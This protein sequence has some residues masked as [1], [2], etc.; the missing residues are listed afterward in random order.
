MLRG[1]IFGSAGALLFT[2]IEIIVA[3]V[4]YRRYKKKSESI[5]KGILLP[6]VILLCIAIVIFTWK[7]L[8]G[9]NS[10]TT[11]SKVDL[12]LVSGLTEAVLAS[13]IHLLAELDGMSNYMEYNENNNFLK[14]YCALYHRIGL[15]GERMLG[16][17]TIDIYLQKDAETAKSRLMLNYSRFDHYDYG[18]N[19]AYLG[20]AEIVRGVDTFMLGGTGRY[21]RTEIR[22]GRYVISISERT[23]SY[24]LSDLRT[25]DVLKILN[26]I[27]LE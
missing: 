21:I 20:R 14:A 2:I 15:D 24:L 16:L 27:A 6:V 23:H 8:L 7:G 25:N 10:G 9:D 26:G 5:S 18:E 1:F 22:V 13:N 11:R 4:V 12:S 17:V 3:I 19:E